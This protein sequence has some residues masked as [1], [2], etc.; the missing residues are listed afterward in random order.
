MRRHDDGAAGGNALAQRVLDLTGGPG[1]EAGER[2]VKDDQPRIV[3]ERARERHFL[4]HAAGKSFAALMRVRLKAEP[5]D[6]L[7]RPRFGY[8]AFDAPEPGYEFEIFERGELVV[9]HRFVRQPGSDPLGGDRIG[10]RVD[11][12]DRDRAGVGT[13]QPD[14]HAQGGGLAGAVGADQ[15]IE[16]AAIDD[17]IDRVDGGAVETLGES[18]R[19]QG[20]RT[21]CLAHDGLCVPKTWPVLLSDRIA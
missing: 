6:Q 8:A 20:D 3:H 10:Q 1:V 2:L 18:A 12:F 17:E 14:H 11:A 5:A 4:L 7:A 15:R 13:Q 21:F 19:C 16:L 9:D